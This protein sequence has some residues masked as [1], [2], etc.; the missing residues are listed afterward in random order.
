MPTIDKKDYF[1]QHIVKSKKKNAT[2]YTK[3]KHRVYASEKWR[4]MRE[5]YLY[6]HP[7]C[8]RC[9]ERG[10]I[11]PAEDVHHRESFGEHLT[12][13]RAYAYDYNNL[14]SVCKHCHGEIHDEQ[15]KQQEEWS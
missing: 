7:L 5:V 2:E 1:K 10:L 12:N 15:R 8:E 13:W 11:T 3:F 14:M 9:E 4:R 6:E